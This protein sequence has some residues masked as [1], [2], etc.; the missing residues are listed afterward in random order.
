MA[1]EEGRHWD[2]PLFFGEYEHAL[3]AQGRVALPSEWRRLDGDGMFVLMPTRGNALALL[4]LGMFRDFIARLRKLAIANP[5]IQKAFSIIGSQSRQ[6]RCDKQGRMAFE[7]RM[8]ESIGVTGQLKMIGSLS[9]ILL[10]APEQWQKPA[11]DDLAQ[12]LDEIQKASEG[13]NE[14]AALLGGIVGKG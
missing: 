3:D 10:C 8:L 14:L 6:C 12:Q 9:Y 13:D 11:A 4:P 2:E 1:S 5:K 7:R